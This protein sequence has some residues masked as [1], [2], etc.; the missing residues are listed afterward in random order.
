M[1]TQPFDYAKVE[2]I[3]PKTRFEL[4]L[5]FVQCLADAGYLNFLAQRGHLDEPSFLRFLKYLKYWQKPPYCSYITCGF[6]IS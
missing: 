4:E 6:L 1:Q 2:T 5:E 3:P